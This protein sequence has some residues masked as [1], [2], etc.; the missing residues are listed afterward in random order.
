[1]KHI[2]Y[3]L[4]LAS[5]WSYLGHERL[6]NIAEKHQASISIYP[7]DLSIVLPATGGIPLPKRSPQRKDYRM[8]ELTRWRE[9]LEV[10]LTLQPKYFPVSDQI[11]AAMVLAIREKDAN[12]AIQ[13]AGC[14]LRAIWAEERDISDRSTL[15]SIA[16]ENNVDGEALM[17][18]EEMMLSSRRADSEAAIERGVYGAPTYIVEDEVFWGQDRL[19]FVDRKLASL[20]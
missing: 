15:V 4:S 16:K 5:P 11:A 19:D 1:M 20:P 13:F 17:E 2:D 9:F 7:V 8:Q 18:Q 6:L 3:Y 12:Q 14:C 10:P